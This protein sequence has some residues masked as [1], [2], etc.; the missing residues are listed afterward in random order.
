MSGNP[1]QGSCFCGAVK[2]TVSGAPMAMGYCHCES[3]RPEAA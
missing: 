3:V 2:L 1:Y